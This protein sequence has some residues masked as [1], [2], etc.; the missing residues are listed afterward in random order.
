M[1]LC[2]A[3][4]GLG[5]RT[6]RGASASYRCEQTA[7]DRSVH[8]VHIGPDRM[9]RSCFKQ[10]GRRDQLSVSVDRE[11]QH[12]DARVGHALPNRSTM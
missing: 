3:N 2:T 7:L 12:G 5:V 10:S 8:P 11:Q 1:P 9:F 6:L 4:A